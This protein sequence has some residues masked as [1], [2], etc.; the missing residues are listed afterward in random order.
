M[1]DKQGVR[2]EKPIWRPSGRSHYNVKESAAVQCVIRAKEMPSQAGLA[3]G[4]LT[5]ALGNQNLPFGPRPRPALVWC[6]FP[7]A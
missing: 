4:R 3:Q 2:A 1:A 5:C 6:L 7:V